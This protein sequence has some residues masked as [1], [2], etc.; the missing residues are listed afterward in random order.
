MRRQVVASSPHTCSLSLFEPPQVD[1]ALLYRPCRI[2]KL[3]HPP[4]ASEEDSSAPSMR[5]CRV[6]LWAPADP[7]S[8]LLSIYTSLLVCVP[9]ACSWPPVHLEQRVREPPRSSPS[10]LTPHLHSAQQGAYHSASI[11][12]HATSC[13]IPT[14]SWPATTRL[15]LFRQ[16]APRWRPLVRPAG[17]P[18]YIRAGQS[19][20]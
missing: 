18:R 11:T 8:I 20:L 2:R 1:A 4:F 6:R 16:A 13:A 17:E 3:V 12:L 14:R 19:I 7:Q 9:A 5:Y 10:A 15:R